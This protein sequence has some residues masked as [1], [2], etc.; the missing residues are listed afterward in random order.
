MLIKAEQ[1][2]VRMSPTKI[3]LVANSVRKIRSPQEVI[4]RLE[5]VNKQAALPLI[6]TIKTAIA[7]AKNNFG[8]SPEDL[9]FKELLINEG[10]FYK[11]GQAVSRGSFHKIIKKTSHIRVILETKEKKTEQKKE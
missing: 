10:A 5:F 4:S 7:N 9:Q 1:K 3:R 11:R 2:F 8:V 6:K